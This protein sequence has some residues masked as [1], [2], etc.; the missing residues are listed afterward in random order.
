LQNT[1]PKFDASN[2][3]ELERIE[4]KLDEIETVLATEQKRRSTENRLRY[5]RPYPKQLAF[6]EAGKLHRERLFM[7]ANQVGKTIAGG[8]EAAMHATG[9]YPDD[10]QGV[11]FNEPTFAWVGSPTGE[12]LRDNPQRILL[13]R[14]DQHGTGTIPKDAIVDT[15]PGAGVPDLVGTIIVSWGGGGDVQ[16]GQSSIGLKSYVQGRE[17]W[18]GETLHWLWFDEEPP[19]DIYTEGL[20]RTNVTQGPVWLTFTPLLGA[21]EVVRRFLLEKSPHRH[22]TVMTIEEAEHFT[23]EQRKVII[24]SYPAHERDAR[25]KGIP[26]LGSGRIFPIAEEKISV[27]PFEIPSHWHRIGAMDFGWDH[28]FAA[29][30]LAWDADHDVVYV[31]KAHRL[32]E[33]TP[34]VHAGAIRAWGPLPWAWPRDGRRETLE[35]AG[36]ALAEQ[37]S[38]QG[39]NMLPMH[40]QFERREIG[41]GGGSVSVEAG[42]MEM[43]T[44]MEAGRL[45]VFSSLLDWWEEFRLYHRK[46]GKVVKEGDDL[47]SATRYGVMMLRFAEQIYRH[48]ERSRQRLPANWLAV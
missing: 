1:S 33:A 34:V 6:H 16:A 26:I 30:E 27:A 35:G 3:Q 8:S 44:R 45:K 2:L 31:I 29:V 22:I 11:V 5:Y 37:Y 25:T 17:K 38:A 15:I 23:A 18:Q 13:G 36:I 12:T 40:A 4:A 48:R 14:G 24:D 28:P 39:L 43:L 20:T 46:D 19:Q 32:R 21:S 10:W 9:R 47:M 7:A 41:E 42:L